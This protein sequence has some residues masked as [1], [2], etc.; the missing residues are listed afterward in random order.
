MVAGGG[1]GGGRYHAGGG[2]AGG[3]VYTAGT[4]LGIRR[5][6]ND[7]RRERGFGGVMR[8]GALMIMGL[9]VKIRRLQG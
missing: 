5:D 1:G 4:T 8:Q 7:R 6:E 9:T 2:G 3:L